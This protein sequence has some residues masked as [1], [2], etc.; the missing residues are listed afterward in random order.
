MAPDE[1]SNP[2]EGDILREMVE[3]TFADTGEEFLDNLVKHLARALNTKCAW[4]TE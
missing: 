1:Q 3:G 2:L 4:V